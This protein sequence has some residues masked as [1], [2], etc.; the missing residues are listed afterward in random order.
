MQRFDYPQR[1]RVTLP[2]HPCVGKTGKVH[3]I[4]IS[5][6]GAWVNMDDPLPPDLRSFEIGDS[7]ANHI[8][9]YPNE[10]EPA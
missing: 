8:I 7:R 10:C 6:N 3:R 4:R 9:L 2:E 1:V 5:D